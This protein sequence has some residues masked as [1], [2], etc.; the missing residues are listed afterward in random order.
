MAETSPEARLLCAVL[1]NPTP[2]PAATTITYRN[3]LAALPLTGCS[4]LDLV[5]LLDVPTRDQ[6]ELSSVLVSHADVERSRGLLQKTISGADE[7]LLAWGSSR[8]GGTTGRVVRQQQGWLIEHLNAAGREHTWMVGGRPRHPSRWRQ[9]V[10]PEKDR[11][12]GATFEE[13]L[14]KVLNVQPLFPTC[15]R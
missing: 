11:V 12:F 9:Y 2:W 4:R 8:V 5:N 7:V 15:H 13:R 14:A 3:L 1:L 10:G 6:V